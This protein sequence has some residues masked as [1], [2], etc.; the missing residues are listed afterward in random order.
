MA[1]GQFVGEV[2]LFDCYRKSKLGSV[3]Y[4]VNLLPI[5]RLHGNAS[6]MIPQRRPHFA[7]Q[8]CNGLGTKHE[9]DAVRDLVWFR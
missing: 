2:L 7:R 6:P 4:F 8:W 9:I 5:K 3:A 1:V